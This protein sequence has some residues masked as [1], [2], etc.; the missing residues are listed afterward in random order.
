M[1]EAISL[2]ELNKLIRSVV[3]TSFDRTFL[4]T[5]EIASCDVKNHC[6]LALVDK[7]HDSIRA[8]IRAVIWANRFS[9][10]SRT[11]EQSTG[12]AIARGIKI[13]FE[14]EVS[15]HER[16]GLKLN[17]LNIDPAYTI[18]EM[19]I[20]RKEIL[21]RLTKDMLI[22]KNREQAFPLVPQRIGIVSSSTSAGYDDLMNH[23]NKNAYGYAFTCALYEAVMQGD[24]AETSIVSA[25]KQCEEDA[26]MLDLVVIVRGGGAQT[27][28]HCF[29]SYEIGKAVALLSLPV[30]SG[31]GHHRDVTVV[32]EVSHSRAKTPTA[33]ADMIIS[34]VRD[35]ENGIDNLAHNLVHGT[36]SLSYDLKRAIS[37]L[38]KRLEIS[39]RNE[40]IRSIHRMNTCITG[41]RLAVK[42]L[43][44]ER[45]ALTSKEN[46]VKMLNPVNVLRRG[47]SISYHKGKAVKSVSDVS[48]GESIRTVI[49]DG[50][51][52]SSIKSLRKGRRSK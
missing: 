4:V 30:I 27:D 5:A 24:R 23:L 20:K 33:A 42:F 45:T 22:H 7:E 3:E 31:I 35:F 10:I 51:F 19:A 8:E 44:N 28:L 9:S 25:I 37:G 15:F 43:Q 49:Y 46:S 38:T 41:L 14:A 50:E 6:Y 34:A 13:L 32:D 40:Q 39:S 16:Y 21:E 26:H 29:D 48:T 11:F 47:Y 52:T 2:Y 12:I 18:G 1:M 17:I 36:R